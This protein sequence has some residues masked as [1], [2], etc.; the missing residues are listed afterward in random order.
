MKKNSTLRMAPPGER[1]P[2]ARADAPAVI[3]PDDN[4]LAGMDVICLSHLRWN[5]VFQRPQQILSR[6]TRQGRVFFFEEPILDDCASARLQLTASPEGVIVAV[7]HI[8]RESTPQMVDILQREL[9]NNLIAQQ[10]IKPFVLW[11]YT[12]MAISFARHLEPAAV[13]YDCMDEL[14]AFR[15]APPILR[16][17]ETQLFRW[18]DVVFTGGRSL[19]EAKRGNHPNVQAFPS[20]ID[21]PHFAQARL[22]QPEPADLA[23]IPRPRLGFIGVVDERFDTELLRALAEA[24]P[25]WHF[26][27]VGP[28]VKIDEADLPRAA[29]IHYLGGKSYAELPAYLSGWE[30]ALL[31]FAHNDSTRYISP[32]KTPEYL[33]AGR[34]VVSTSIRDVV[35][36]YGEMELVH[37]ADE[38]QEF[39]AAIEKALVQGR[40]DQEWLARVDGYLAKNSW[41]QTCRAMFAQV[42]EVIA[43]KQQATILTAKNQTANVSREVADRTTAMLEISGD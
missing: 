37:I 32:T 6:R 16:E 26:V 39:V 15:G 35:R 18:A 21:V 25:E 33:A 36:P 1:A 13:V 42:A 9:L 7:P 22:A 23:D 34:P 27:I 14:S 40:G 17:R 2:A 38:P 41:N 11:V 43:K 8:P 19:Y 24:K 10:N 20:S 28:V 30:V 29:N 4:V 3:S 31:L 5:F 12:P